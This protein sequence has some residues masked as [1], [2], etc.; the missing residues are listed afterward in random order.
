MPQTVVSNYIQPSPTHAN[1]WGNVT[2]SNSNHGTSALGLRATGSPRLLA[3]SDLAHS[4]SENDSWGS[5]RLTCHPADETVSRKYKDQRVSGMS[6]RET[7]A[8]SSGSVDVS[9]PV[10]SFIHPAN[11][12]CGLSV[13]EA[14]GG[15]WGCEDKHVGHFSCFRAACRTGGGGGLSNP[16]PLSETQLGKA[17]QEKPQYGV[18][19][20]AWGSSPGLPWGVVGEY[21]PAGRDPH[22]E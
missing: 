6:N 4:R 21:H 14:T 17:A 2:K 18:R 19:V 20:P 1:E 3:S 5:F 22:A 11:I 9:V 10:A 15:G 7:A 13:R 16:S 12:D 8:N